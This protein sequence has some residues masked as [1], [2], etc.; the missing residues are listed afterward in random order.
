M[1]IVVGGEYAN[2]ESQLIGRVQDFNEKLGEGNALPSLE[3]RAK[4][5]RVGALGHG[6]V[7]QRNSS[8]QK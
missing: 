4:T 6:G 7:S 1:H 3:G 5:H 8:Q 2:K